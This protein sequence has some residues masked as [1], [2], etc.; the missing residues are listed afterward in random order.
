MNLIREFEDSEES[1]R[2][3]FFIRTH[4]SMLLYELY[5]VMTHKDNLDDNGIVVKK[6]TPASD[7]MMHN[8]H[9][10]DIPEYFNL[11]GGGFF[12]LIG[13]SFIPY[14][15]VPRELVK[16]DGRVLASEIRWVI[17][18][19]KE[20]Q[21]AGNEPDEE[22]TGRLKL[23]EFFIL[24]CR[25]PLFVK[26]K[27]YVPED[28]DYWR[29]DV[30]SRRFAPF[31]NAKNILF[32]VTAP[33]VNMIYPRYAYDRF[34]PDLYDV[35]FRRKDSLLNSLLAVT[36]HDK[37]PKIANLMSCVA[38][39]NMEVLDDL[40]SWLSVQRTKLRPGGKGDLGIMCDFYNQF[41]AKESSYSV[42]TYDRVNDDYYTITFRPISLLADV[43]SSVMDDN[44]LSA[45][46]NKIY[47]PVD[48][49]I[50]DARYTYEEI[51]SIIDGKNITM[52]MELKLK[53]M[54]ETIMDDRVEISSEEF[55]AGLVTYPMIDQSII[56][57]LFDVPLAKLYVE[58]FME[59]SE[60]RLVS[61]RDENEQ[62]KDRITQLERQRSFVE[63]SIAAVKETIRDVQHKKNEV[64]ESRYQC[65]YDVSEL[66]RSRKEYLTR[67][68]EVDA[69]FSEQTKEKE[70][71][72][73]RIADLEAKLR[74]CNQRRDYIEQE[75]SSRKLPTDPVAGLKQT[76]LQ[77]V[78]EAGEYEKSLQLL[79]SNLSFILSS[80][81]E[82]VK[83]REHIKEQIRNEEQKLPETKSRMEAYKNTEEALQNEIIRLEA[84]LSDHRDKK[85]SLNRNIS[86]ANQEKDR[87]QADLAS[88]QRAHRSLIMRLR[89]M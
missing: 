83:E 34:N 10:S 17:N 45:K 52:D 27:R 22:F 75:I 79:N 36:R 15:S 37:R 62:L 71:I 48:S 25:R 1:R 26:N 49:F 73:K 60:F 5:D 3:L 42:K 24:N 18:R 39:R 64:K 30:S 8:S 14:N 33:F 89:S 56:A 81:D 76:R 11:V 28:I 80:I 53:S 87:I 70:A 9:Y 12:T 85:T 69:K 19:D 35:A 13:N 88:L 43:L 82:S 20:L 63:E 55:I 59:Q 54:A 65:E 21:E 67:L 86:E 29:A 66:L 4:Y 2:L 50:A 38:I 7:P 47:D 74:I 23:V 40:Q 58:K 78:E 6:Q 44:T 46:F 77:I 16:I 72:S 51:C 31:N 57:T 84:D 68:Q 61:L 41:S 32:D